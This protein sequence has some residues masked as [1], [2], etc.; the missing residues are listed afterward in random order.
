MNQHTVSDSYPMHLVDSILSKLRDA[1]FL[2]SIDLRKAFL[3]IPLTDTSKTKTAFSVFGVGSFEFTRMIFGLKNG[4]RTMARLIDIVIDPSILPYC[5][6]YLD[7]IIVATP[8]FELHIDTLKKLFNRLKDANL[9]INMEKSEFCR[10]SLHFL[11]FFL[12]KD[13]SQ[14]CFCNFKL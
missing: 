2:T 14:K 1:K 5:F 8:T 3:Q 10:D 13:R 9:T 6:C 12:D 11:G 7:D 4:P